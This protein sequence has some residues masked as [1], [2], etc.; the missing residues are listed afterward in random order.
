[1]TE[2]PKIR[3][4]LADD[5]DMLREGLSSFLRACPDMETIGEATDGN[6]AVQMCRELRPDIVLM[7]L[8]MPEMDGI[9]ATQIISKELPGVRIIALSSN[10]DDKSVKAVL[11]AG[12][13]G[14][15][16]KNISSSRL[17]DAIRTAHSG[18]PVLSP[19]AMAASM[20]PS[21]PQSKN[22]MPLGG[23]LTH[24]EKEVLDQMVSGQTNAEIASRMNISLSTVKNHVS[25]ILEKMG[26]ANRAEVI[27][28]VLNTL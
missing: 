3:I 4:L 9:T 22:F 26:A 5:H 23:E 12:A 24:R 13:C 7:D 14:Y 27:Y 25:S 6:E 28:K 18:M 11:Q 21:A 2:T 17:A 19:E 20:S 16:L 1:M 8:M 15:L 10:C